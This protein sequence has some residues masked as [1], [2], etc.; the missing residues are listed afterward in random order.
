MLLTI[1]LY[2]SLL[3]LVLILCSHCLYLR[4]ALYPICSKK[5][6]WKVY[7][8]NCHTTYSN[9]LVWKFP[10]KNV[11]THFSFNPHIFA[12]LLSFTILMTK[13]QSTLNSTS[14]MTSLFIECFWGWGVAPKI[15]TFSGRDAVHLCIKR[16]TVLR[17]RGLKVRLAVILH[18]TFIYVPW[19]SGYL[20]NRIYVGIVQVPSPPPPHT[21]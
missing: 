20:V 3:D 19:S 16:V 6:V 1:V 10:R 18:L 11:R 9:R 15:P 8:E 12:V 2:L 5:L 4:K 14:K 17:A 7:L 13:S 21:H